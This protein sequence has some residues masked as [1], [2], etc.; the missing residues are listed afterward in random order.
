MT[1][2]AQARECPRLTTAK[3]LRLRLP[4]KAPPGSR[5]RVVATLHKFSRRQLP[6]QHPAIDPRDRNDEER[7]DRSHDSAPQHF[8]PRALEDDLTARAF[9]VSTDPAQ[10]RD[11]NPGPSDDGDQGDP[12]QQIPSEINPER[13]PEG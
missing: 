2:R 7:A 6:T 11:E 13:S 12:Q 9:D 1:S 5:A 3:A 4:G 10:L 8:E